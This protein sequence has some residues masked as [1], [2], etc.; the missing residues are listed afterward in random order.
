MYIREYMLFDKDSRKHCDL[1]NHSES[2]KDTFKTLAPEMTVMVY[3]RRYLVFSEEKISR[4]LARAISKELFAYSS[5]AQW[6]GHNGKTK[7]LME[8][9]NEIRVSNSVMKKIYYFS[10]GGKAEW[11]R[12]R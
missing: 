12:S 3:K 1:R 8:C 9:T 10:E 6:Y 2:I 11:A 7:R 5:L 4:K